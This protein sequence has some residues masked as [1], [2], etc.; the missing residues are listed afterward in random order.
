M[1]FDLKIASLAR[2]GA[3]VEYARRTAEA[4]LEQDPTLARPEHVLL[5]RLRSRYVNRG[6]VDFGMI[7]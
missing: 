6:E 3:I 2:D 7:S 5:A 1:A 4:L